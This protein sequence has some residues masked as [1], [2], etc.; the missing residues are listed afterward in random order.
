MA[1]TIA[2]QVAEAIAEVEGTD[3]EHLNIM[4]Q[5]HVS[6]DAIREL[7]RHESSSWSLQFETQDHVVEVLGKNNTVIVDDSERR[8]LYRSS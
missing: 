4:L 2:K 7:V 8:E 1:D 6:T 5:N 3:V